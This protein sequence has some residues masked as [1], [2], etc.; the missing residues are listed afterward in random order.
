MS[1]YGNFIIIFIVTEAMKFYC[2][3][4][5]VQIV[6]MSCGEKCHKY[7]HQCNIIIFVQ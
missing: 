2:D 6:I 5:F 1:L 4:V 7:K 3:C